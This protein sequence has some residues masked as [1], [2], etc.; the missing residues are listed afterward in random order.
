MIR[1]NLQKLTFLIFIGIVVFPTTIYCQKLSN[2]LDQEINI[3]LAKTNLL[4]VVNKLAFEYN[5][6]IGLEVDS[7]YRQK[8]FEKMS[9]KNKQLTF[10]DEIE[11]K[12]GTLRNILNNLIKQEPKYKW[13][14][15]DGVIN[16]YPIESRDL[17]LKRILDINI[18]KKYKE[19][20]FDTSK[21]LDTIIDF[22]GVQTFLTQE[23]LTFLKHDP[24]NRIYSY[25]DTKVKMKIENKN[26]RDILNQFIR[27]S[28]LKLWV[29]E[30]TGEK[31]EFVSINF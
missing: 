6:P 1:K 11:I 12:K 24:L 17:L 19:I 21:L 25:P 30:R 27:E 14:A 26:I 23:K 29:L 4:Y 31:K 22:G 20:N 16:I 10:L 18:K 15:I 2:F 7:S 28:R 3:N 5:I 8:D 9:L 13:K